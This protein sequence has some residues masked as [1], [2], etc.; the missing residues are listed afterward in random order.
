MKM[1]TEIL[2]KAS[3]LSFANLRHRRVKVGLCQFGTLGSR[4]G[5][6]G[7]RVDVGVKRLPMEDKLDL[8]H[9]GS[10]S[11]LRRCSIYSISSQQ[12]YPIDHSEYLLSRKPINR[13]E[14]L[15]AHC[16]DSEVEHLISAFPYFFIRNLEFMQW[17][18]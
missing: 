17:K 15:V 2:M 16:S 11:A 4:H 18:C 14:L 5:A 7:G 13:F 6:T 1:T 8:L 10:H 3:T 12:G 9:P